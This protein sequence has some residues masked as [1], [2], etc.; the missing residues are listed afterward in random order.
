MRHQTGDEFLSLEQHGQAGA[1]FSS[2][3]EPGR[4]T[5]SL[6]VNTT[7]SSHMF[8][9]QEAEGDEARDGFHSSKADT[10]R[11]SYLDKVD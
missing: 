3:G 10:S 6:T 2:L 8:T 9:P 1:G 4:L 5:G 11:E 7:Y